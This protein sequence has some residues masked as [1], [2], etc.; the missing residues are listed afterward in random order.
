MG[1][2]RPIDL[3]GQRMAAIPA[4]VFADMMMAQPGH[5]LHL[6]FRPATRPGPRVGGRA[7]HLVGEL[8]RGASSAL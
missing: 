1:K 2:G 7:L 3:S 6:R 4:A 8:L 5:S